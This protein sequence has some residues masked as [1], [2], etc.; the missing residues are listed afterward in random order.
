MLFLGIA[1]AQLGAEDEAADWLRRGI[2]ANRNQPM[3]HFHLAAALA[4]LG[5]L[6]EARVAAQTGLSFNPGFTIRRYRVN[7]PSDN[8]PFLAGRERI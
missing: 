3:L 6:D 5:A 2:E 7:T 8:P 1:K 4:R